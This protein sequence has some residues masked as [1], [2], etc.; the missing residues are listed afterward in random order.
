MKVVSTQVLV[1]FWIGSLPLISNATA[2]SLI[3]LWRRNT[4]GVKKYINCSYHLKPDY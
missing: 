1:I 3:E 2:V 4:Y